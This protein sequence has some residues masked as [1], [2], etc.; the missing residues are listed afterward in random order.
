MKAWNRFWEFSPR[1]WMPLLFRNTLAKR[2]TST[3]MDS[4]SSV[5]SSQYPSYNTDTL[6]SSSS[7]MQSGRKS[8]GLILIE[9]QEDPKKSCTWRDEAKMYVFSFSFKF[10]LIF[11]VTTFKQT[12]WHF[13]ISYWMLHLEDLCPSEPQDFRSCWP[14]TTWSQQD[15]FNDYWQLWQLFKHTLVLLLPPHS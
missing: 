7:P 15:I 11:S 5:V 14:E 12:Q 13:I 8:K 10:N 9:T 2:S 4:P 3:F 6:V 1:E